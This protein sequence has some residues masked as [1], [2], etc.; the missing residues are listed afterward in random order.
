MKMA[1]ENNS[2]SI[3]KALE[4]AREAQ[5]AI[6]REAQKRVKNRS[7]SEKVVRAAAGVVDNCQ[8]DEGTEGAD[9]AKSAVTNLWKSGTVG[10][11]VI[12][13]AAI[14]VIK[15]LLLIF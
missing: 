1:E 3:Q 14:I 4:A 7:F 13:V 12:V 2:E 10:K 6:Q 9:K 11:V 5:A 15:V 8:P